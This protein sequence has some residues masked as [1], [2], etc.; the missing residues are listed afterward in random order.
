MPMVHAI[1]YD[2]AINNLA[3]IAPKIVRS[4]GMGHMYIDMQYVLHNNN[5]NNS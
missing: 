5:T 3:I 2:C 4:Q 1:I